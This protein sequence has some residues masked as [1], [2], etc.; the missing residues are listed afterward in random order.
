M[1][2]NQGRNFK[3]VGHLLKG[4]NKIRDYAHTIFSTALLRI[5]PGRN[6][7]IIERIHHTSLFISFF[8]FF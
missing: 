6:T 3:A 2:M 4:Y 8:I 5:G 1:S 7:I